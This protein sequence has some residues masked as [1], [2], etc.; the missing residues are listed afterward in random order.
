MDQVLTYGLRLVSIAMDKCVLQAYLSGL[1]PKPMGLES[2]STLLNTSIKLR[3]WSSAV[4]SL[5][6][7]SPR[8]TKQQ[9]GS[10][11]NSR[12]K[13]E[14]LVLRSTVFHRL[15]QSRSSRTLPIRP[16]LP[17]KQHLHSREMVIDLF[18]LTQITRIPR[19][20]KDSLR[21]VYLLSKTVQMPTKSQ[22]NIDKTR[23]CQSETLQIK[24]SF[25]RNKNLLRLMNTECQSEL[26]F[27][28]SPKFPFLV[29][30]TIS[31]KTYF[32]NHR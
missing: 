20:K 18:L 9:D 26:S 32:H 15:P 1:R 31:L 6:F 27:Y 19:F 13:R 21:E 22:M 11:A 24:R 25:L 23:I 5:N 14:P 4:S 8:K 12:L 16:L 7:A 10:S 29:V 28:K 30:S 2:S 3:Y 17:T